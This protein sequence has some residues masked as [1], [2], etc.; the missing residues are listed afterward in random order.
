MRSPLPA[1]LAVATVAAC[2]AP[3]APSVDAGTD[4]GTTTV[5]ALASDAASGDTASA[6][7]AG[8]P[9]EAATDVP[10]DAPSDAPRAP[11]DA[12]ADAWNLPPA[13]D[14]AL[15]IDPPSRDAGAASDA[16]VSAPLGGFGLVAWFPL[17]GDFHDAAGAHPLTADG[18]PMFTDETWT[19]PGRA[20]GPT[21]RSTANGASSADFNAVDATAGLTLEGWVR[22]RDNDA[23][24][25]LFGWGQSADGAPTLAVIDNYGFVS[26]RIG[27]DYRNVFVANFDRVAGDA[28]WHHVALVLPPGFLGGAPFALYVDGVPATLGTQDRVSPGVAM[29]VLAVR[30]TAANVFGSPFHAGAFGGV[31]GGQLQVDEVRVWGRALTAAEV[32][33]VSTAAG[34]GAR[35]LPPTPPSWSPGP[36]CVPQPATARAELG[37]RVLTDDTVAVVTDANPWM[38]QQLHADCGRFLDALDAQGG[39]VLDWEVARYYDEAALTTQARVRPALQR[40]QGAPGWFD[41]RTIAGSVPS[42]V[43]GTWPQSM[44]EWVLPTSVPTRRPVRTTAAE[45]AQFSFVHLS[46][47]LR[48]GRDYALDDGAGDR[49]AFRFDP[50]QTVSWALQVDQLGYALD[51]P[52]FGYLGAW[53]GPAGALDLHRFDGATFTVRNESDGSAAFTGAIHHRAS[54]DTYGADH[55]PLTGADVYELDFSALRT[56]G[57]YHLEVPGA[58][59]SWSFTLGDDALGEAFYTHARALYH[60]RCGTDIVASVTP[61]RRGDG[62]GT[63]RRSTAPTEPDDY[64]DHAAAGWGFR[65]AAGAYVS[66]AEFDM[67]QRTATTTVLPGVRGGWH[68]A[69]DFDRASWHLTAED[70]LAHAY[71]YAP[72]RFTDG[73][74]AIP[75]SGNGAPDLL[76]EAVWG[77]DVFRLGQES[78]GR[79]AMHVETTSHPRVEDPG[80]DTQPYYLGL[81]TRKSS[82]AYAARAALLGR[83]LTRAGDTARATVWIDSARRAFA[84]GTGSVRVGFTVPGTTETWI[85]PATP[86]VDRRLEAA[87]QLW[88]AT[89]DTAYRA[90][91]DAPELDAAFRALANDP[92]FMPYTLVDVALAAAR[93]PAEWAPLAQSRVLTLADAFVTPQAS[94]PYR[95]LWW[96]PTY[97]Y[98]WALGWGQGG[99]QPMRFAVAAYLLT[100]QQRYRDA[101]LLGV[102]WMQGTNPQGRVQTTGLGSVSQLAVLHLPSFADDIAEPV[103]GLTPFGYGAGIPYDARTRVWGIYADALPATG[104][105]PIAVSLM[106]APWSDP[107]LPLADLGNVLYAQWPVWRRY[108]ALEAQNPATTEMD[109]RG[110]ACAASIT[111]MLL[112]PG[113]TPSAALRARRPRTDD[114]LRQSWWAL[115]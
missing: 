46:E 2:S 102:N 23:G 5:D 18:P 35:C 84:F 107:A 20:Y 62:H 29:G 97:G 24:G 73:Q 15:R 1:F 22:G 86:P 12:V 13:R 100:G 59:R 93:F 8:T 74:L 27:R 112:G 78:D 71:L 109:V 44:R 108:V 57:R 88:L 106:P 26:V 32:R 65:D 115:P 105:A 79:V 51:A 75:E 6:L 85:E 4:A 92:A 47:P 3:S 95:K 87:V 33:T 17:D 110:M 53:L 52:K 42:T 60:A 113:W 50:A 83:A 66:H 90:L 34:D 56:A 10:A 25:V 98:F 89:G 114:E 19:R 99:F 58:G 70:D 69:G 72:D 101:A 64:T 63:T 82:L 111:G 61:W 40:A 54:P 81:A 104:F 94:D 16:A 76:D 103:P 45:V 55:Q 28:C 11:D 41:V 39:S 14:A 30:N 31:N 80:V 48:A 68:D 21:G 37:L 96:S 36:H 38:T 7:D 77:I 49:L 67:V 43:L 9:A 91:L